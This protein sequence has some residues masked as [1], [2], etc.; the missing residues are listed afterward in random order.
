VTKDPQH[1]TWVSSLFVS[2]LVILSLTLGFLQYRWIGEVSQAERERLKAGLQTSL[3]RFGQDFDSA[4]IAACAAIIPARIDPD[5]Q[6]RERIYARR[7]Q[8]WHESGRRNELFRSVSVAV[9]ADEPLLLKRL[10][11]ATGQW[12]AIDWPD[13]WSK[14]RD[15]LLARFEGRPD[16]RPVT[17]D[18]ADLVEFPIFGRTGAGG[19]RRESEWLIFELNMQYIRSQL[20]PELLQ[21]HLGGTGT[22]Q[23]QAEVVVAA[24]PDVR[25]FQTEE[26]N[27]R[28]DQADASVRFFDPFREPSMRRLVPGGFEPL[29]RMPPMRGGPLG[30]REGPP[31]G[32]GGPPPRGRPEAFGNPGPMGRGRWLLSVRHQSGSLETAVERGRQRNLAVTTALVALLML[33]LLALIRYTRRAQRLAE[34][35]MQFVAG[36]SHELRTPLSVMRTAGH[37]LRQGRVARDPVKVE[38]YGVLIEDE[39]EKLTGIVE[40]VLRFANARAGRVIGSRE[41][42]SAAGLI[43]E[44]INA[45]RRAIADSGCVVEKN[46]EPRL[47]L[48]SGEHASLSHALQNLVSNA[49]KYGSGGGHIA[50]RA[51]AAPDRGFVEIRVQDRGRGIPASEIGQVFDPFYRGAWVVQQQI[52]GTGLGLSLVKRIIEAHGGTV[53]VASQEGK[54]TEFLVRLPAAA[55]EEHEFKHSAD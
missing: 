22:V 5:Q 34:L 9:P 15:R 39:S 54:G 29:R 24:Q 16:G 38:Q 1:R 45:N 28:A 10:D 36:V 48:I 49:A 8:Q 35:Q 53:A 32:P 14:V 55:E 43:G 30:M 37:N 47:P 12:N 3:N 4:L 44:A 52:H 21:R 18:I 50:I 6:E 2:A 31:R 33:A 13:P 51:T 20:I 40:Q 26:A 19:G 46:I 23:F 25:I 41:R 42:L 27:F 7:Y 17:E 11:L